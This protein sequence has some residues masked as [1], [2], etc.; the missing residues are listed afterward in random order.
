MLG[1]TSIISFIFLAAYLLVASVSSAYP[2]LSFSIQDIK[3]PIFQTRAITAQ[4]RESLSGQKQLE[5]S[6]EEITIRN[7]VFKNIRMVCRT[8]QLG[9]D[10]MECNDGQLQ[11]KDLFPSPVPLQFTAFESQLHAHLKPSQHEHWKF[12]LR[13]DDTFWQTML[14]IE[15]GKMTHLTR[16]LPETK[17]LPKLT[18]GTIDGSIQLNGDKTGLTA[19]HTDLMV[20][21]L[22]FSDQAG[23]HAGETISLSLTASAL[24]D[25][26]HLHWNFH[27]EMHWQQGAV[28][29]QPLFFTGNDHYLNIHGAFDT[30]N[31]HL[32]NSHLILADI[33]TFNFS[34]T[35]DWPKLSLNAVELEA[36]NIALSALFDQMIKP[37]LSDTI[38]AEL[39]IDG[40]SDIALR[41]QNDVL[42]EIDLH[43]DDVNIIDKRDRFAF[44][45]IDAHIPWQFHNATIA[46]ISLLNGHVLRIPF[47]SMRVPLEIND[48]TIFLPRLEMPI[49]DGTLK[50]KEFSATYL[51]GEWQWEFGGELTSVSMEALTEALQI[52]T[53]HGVLSGYI[54][55]VQF[56]GNNVSINGVLQIN[57]FDGSVVIHKLKLIEPMGLAPHLTADIAMRNLDLGLLTKTFSF[58]KVEGRVDI[59]VGDLEL[60]NWQPIHF[61]IH[62]FSS[63]GK[64][65]RRISQAA[66]QNI[67]ALG[68]EGAV[69][70]IQRSFL[71][72]FEEFSYAEIGWRCALRFDVCHMGGI[73]SEPDAKYTLIKGGGI[74]AINVMGYNREVGWQE[75][76]SRLQR[77]T[78]EHDPIIQ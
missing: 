4:I 60:T 77:I 6:I 43:L 16:F 27:S 72:F 34:S 14:E 61:D 10:A 69:M 70:A 59:D 46:D 26:K 47:G 7:Q 1:R 24:F 25:S 52:Q 39:E 31:L 17:E 66:I 64:Y 68:G 62:L 22:A 23:M 54:P 20:N 41:I 36:D 55:E 75:L 13:W 78:Q 3:S 28:F 2:Q 29:W 8:F 67:S 74:P 15:A 19:M 51:D 30:K 76:I 40:H 42:Q 5:I 12:N 71:R 50:L 58:G 9:P 73:E 57:I 45:R 35:V 21:E 53:M 56:D 11:I 38:L 32:Q 65:T 18:A 44:H 63:P 49:L 48:Y 33:G 37:F